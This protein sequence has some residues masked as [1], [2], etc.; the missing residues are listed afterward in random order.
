MLT[1][2]EN[3]PFTGSPRSKFFDV[4]LHGNR[5]VVENVLD[6][7]LGKFVAMEQLLGELID[8]SSLDL[9]IQT[10]LQE[11]QDDIYEAKNDLYI[12]LVGDVLTQ[13]E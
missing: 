12:S 5:S 10:V 4:M 3:D 2:D 1:V 8:P 7:L 11:K 13:H 6:D 9:Q